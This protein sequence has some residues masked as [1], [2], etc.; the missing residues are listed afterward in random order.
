M[1][2]GI[3]WELTP[4]GKAHLADLD[5]K[6][7]DRIK[8]KHGWGTVVNEPA[9]KGK[10]AVKLDSG[11]I[12]EVRGSG[13]GP[14]C[15]LDS[16]KPTTAATEQAEFYCR[17]FIR[18][19]TARLIENGVTAIDA[20]ALHGRVKAQAAKVGKKPPSWSMM[21]ETAEGLGG[22]SVT[23]DIPGY[24]TRV[25][26]PPAHLAKM[27]HGHDTWH[28]E[29]EERPSP[30][31]WISGKHLDDCGT[32]QTICAELQDV[33]EEDALLM[34]AASKMWKA[35]KVISLDKNIRGWLAKNDPQ[36]LKQADKAI[37]EAEGR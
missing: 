22:F 36:A 1:P 20:D 16:K 17:V 35:L 5:P 24:G 27:F 4:E 34:A 32:K 9:P 7:G 18:K 13:S 30:F 8:T 28:L 6:P 3:R 33:S 11:A 21:L 19:A 31:F 26:L 10:V 29:K 2:T 25:K 15:L 14:C 12:V 23:S 37:A